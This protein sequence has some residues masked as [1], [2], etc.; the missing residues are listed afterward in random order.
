MPNRPERKLTRKE[1]IERQLNGFTHKLHVY[2]ATCAWH[3][4]IEQTGRIGPGIPCCPH[5]RGVLLQIDESKW[6]SGAERHET[7][8]F[9]RYREFLDWINAQ[10]RCYENADEAEAAWRLDV[11]PPPC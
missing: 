2:G 9:P 4:P 3:G 8:N 11:S 6:L 1:K 5:C 7:E 10:P